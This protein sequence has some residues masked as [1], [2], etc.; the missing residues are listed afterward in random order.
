MEDLTYYQEFF[1]E[2]EKSQIDFNKSSY[3][4]IPLNEFVQFETKLID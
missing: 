4:D 2:I 3:N 1:L